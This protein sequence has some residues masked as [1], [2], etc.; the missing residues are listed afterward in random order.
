MDLTNFASFL[1]VMVL[2]FLRERSLLAFL[3]E[4]KWLLPPPEYLTLPLL[5]SLKR[6][7]TPLLVFNFPIF[8]PSP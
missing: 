6:L 1:P 8:S 3:L 2:R 4:A 7:A 5:V